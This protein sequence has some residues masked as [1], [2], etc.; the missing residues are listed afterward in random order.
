[1]ADQ[2]VIKQL[3]RND[4][5]LQK[6]MTELV[7]SINNLTKRVDNLVGIFEEAA[8]NVTSFSE[9]E[10]IKPLLD[11]LDS[12][13]EQNR[14]IAKGLIALEQYV[15]DKQGRIMPG[16]FRPRQLQEM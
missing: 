1:M 9:N 4:V 7:L 8:K 14:V 2:D 15:R 10:E 3:L 13:T 11:K 6:K 16:Q 5:I 12:L